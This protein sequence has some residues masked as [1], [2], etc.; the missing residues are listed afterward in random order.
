V[1][2]GGVVDPGPSGRNTAIGNAT[3][4]SGGGSTALGDNAV[5]QGQ[6]GTALGRNAHSS[7]QA[8]NGIA[9]GNHAD[10]GVFGSGGAYGEDAI[11][12]GTNA[13]ANRSTAL[14]G[15]GGTGGVSIGANTSSGNFATAVGDGATA[16]AANSVALGSGSVAT[17][18]NTVSVGSSGSERRIVNLAPGVNSTDAVNVSQLNDVEETAEGAGALALAAASLWFDDRPGKFS[19]SGGGAF[20]GDEGAFALGAGYTTMDQRFRFDLIGGGAPGSGEFGV[21]GGV[22]VTL[23]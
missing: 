19:L 6:N 18:A 9:I 7:P 13:N 16:N 2:T 22:S 15:P 11:A 20:Y 8:T 1:A 3:I 23:N 4:A 14:G 12:I 17:Q 5:A 10:G 21:G